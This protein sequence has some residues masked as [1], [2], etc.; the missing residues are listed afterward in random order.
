[1]SHSIRRRAL[2]AATLLPFLAACGALSA[3]NDAAEPLRVFE[4]QPPE[5]LPTASGRPLARDVIVE[6]PTTSGA[7]E[8]DRIMIRP[9]PLE[10][11]YLPEA[12]WGEVAP[13]MM[14]TLMLRTLDR[15]GAFQFV[16]RRPLGPSGDYAIVTELMDFQAVL[17]ADGESAEVQVALIARIVREE[18]V[19]ILA[20]RSFSARQAT[21]S[22]SDDDIVT[23]FDAAAGRVMAEFSTWTLAT[24]GVR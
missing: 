6:L 11:Q 22:L 13:I 14:Q 8:T 19:R 23:A 20:T 12:R 21:L 17:A 5:G 16:G 2:I 9:G 15:T 4:L 1:M 3:L 10:A 24:L 7:L 18:G